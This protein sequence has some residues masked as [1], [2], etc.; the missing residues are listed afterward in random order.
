MKK[1]PKPKAGVEKPRTQVLVKELT[2]LCKLLE[3]KDLEFL[4]H[5]AE[6][7]LHNARVVAMR[8]KN[9]SPDDVP[10]K[11]KKPAKGA[12]A[13]S[14]GTPSDVDGGS[15]RVEKTEGN[16]FNIYVDRSRVFF[17]RE[18]MRSLAKICHASGSVSEGTT[19]L[20]RWFER[21][22]K[23]FLNDGGIETSGHPALAEL[24]GLIRRTYT[25]KD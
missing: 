13:A 25:V 12:A 20:Y 15:V 24:Y 4:K 18:E 5:Q 8:K 17:N 6:I 7:L 22:R 21:E 19:R 3:E 9:P 14:G 23:D 11:T 1:P 2:A 16:F 10:K